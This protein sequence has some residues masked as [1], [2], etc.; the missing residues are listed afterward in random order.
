[1]AHV[2]RCFELLGD[3]PAVAAAERPPSCALETALQGPDDPGERRD[4]PKL[5]HKM[6][7]R[8]CKSGRRPLPGAINFAKPMWGRLGS[9]LAT[10]NVVTP[11]Y[12]HVMSAEIEKETLANWKLSALA[13]GRTTQ[14]RSFLAIRKRDFDFLRQILSGQQELPPRWKRCTNDGM[15]T[16]ASLGSGVCREH[17]T[18]TQ[19]RLRRRL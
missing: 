4:P 1:V 19:N 12:F 9:P 2:G 6:S 17:F 10:L 18:P 11:D 14:P 16:W 13:C 8:N 3:N 7:V 5:Y 15:A